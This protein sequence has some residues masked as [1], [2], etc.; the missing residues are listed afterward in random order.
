MKKLTE[1]YCACR[2]TCVTVA[3]LVFMLAWV[4][5]EIKHWSVCMIGKCIDFYYYTIKGGKLR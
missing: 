1:V 2:E 5:V 3:G 4:A